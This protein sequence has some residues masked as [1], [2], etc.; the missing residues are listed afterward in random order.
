MAEGGQ[1]KY[2][3]YPAYK[4]SGVEWLGDIPEGWEARKLKFSAENMPSNIDKKTKPGEQAVKLCNYTDVYYSEVIEASMNFMSASATREQVEKFTLLAGDTIITKDSEDPNDIAIPTFV[5]D[6]LAGVV[7]GYHLSIIRPIEAEFGGY[8]KRCFECSFARA[9]FAVSANGLT[10]YGLGTYPLDNAVFPVPSRVEAI[11][12]AA[13]LDHETLK[14]DGLIAKQQRLIALLEEK[15]QA[16][17]SHAVT[18]GLDPT[19]PLRRSGI[20]WLGDVPAHWDTRK[21]NL[22]LRT[23][24]G[25]AFKADD[26]CDSGVRVAKA[27]DIKNL[28]FQLSDVFLPPSFV[29]KHP[30]AVLKE[31]NIVLSTVGSNPSVKNSAVG[32]VGRV[33]AMQDGSLLNQNTVVF[34]IATEGSNEDYLFAALLTQGYRDHLD[35]NAHGTANQSSL[36]VSDMLDFIVPMPNKSEQAEIARYLQFYSKTLDDLGVSSHL[37]ITLLKERRTA[38]ISAAVTGKIDLRDWQA[39]DATSDIST[40]DIDQNEEALA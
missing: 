29:E 12:I 18:K 16:V 8:I 25:I 3:P 27:S 33:P 30:K 1:A 13:F 23:R 39:P 10:R 38:L 9:Y 36:N 26:F 6:D 5:K 24:K 2:R 35:L 28:T 22:L 15:R 11:K 31:G 37:A 40:Q 19:A 21:L 32:Q 17:I 4:P 7:C 34:D 14:I 20:D